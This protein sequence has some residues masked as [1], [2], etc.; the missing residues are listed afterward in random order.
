[1]ND[2]QVTYD[3]IKHFRQYFKRYWATPDVSR[4]IDFAAAEAGEMIDAWIRLKTGSTFARNTARPGDQLAVVCE[5]ADTVIMLL[6]ALQGVWDHWD[7]D[8]FKQRTIPLNEPSI[9]QAFLTVTGVVNAYHYTD[10]QTGRGDWI[11]L[12]IRACRQLE[13]L[14]AEYTDQP[15]SHIVANRLRRV[16]YKH[17]RTSKTGLY[18][19]MQAIDVIGYKA[20]EIKQGTLLHDLN[21]GQV[22]I[23]VALGLEPYTADQIVVAH[24]RP[25]RVNGM[26]DD[27]IEVK[28]G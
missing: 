14:A 12:A 21:N 15:I 6:T 13:R 7:Q 23:K 11:T 2:L 4:S 9:R 19:G 24:F 5:I 16:F 8:E 25:N 22:V 10:P 18:D 17:W 20:G 27:G 3:K 1:M 26:L 28:G